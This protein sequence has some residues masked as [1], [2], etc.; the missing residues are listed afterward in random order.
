MSLGCILWTYLNQKKFVVSAAQPI[1]LYQLCMGCIVMATAIFPLSMQGKEST[2]QLDKACMSIPWLLFLGFVISVSAILAKTWRLE[3]LVGS[4]H[5]MRRVKVKARD[6]MKPFIALMVWNVAML[7]GWTIVSPLKY[8]R[9][10]TNNFDIFGRSLESYGR[11]ESSDSWVYLFAGLA[12]AANTCGV[13]FAAYKCYEVRNVTVYFSE[14]T[15]LTWSMAS[16]TETLL[17]GAP[18]LVVV[19]DDPSAFFLVAASL[20]CVCCWAFLL[21]MF[22]SKLFHK[23]SNYKDAK[24]DGQ[25]RQEERLYSVAVGADSQFEDEYDGSGRINIRR[26]DSTVSS[27]YKSSNCNN[28]GGS[29]HHSARN[30]P[31]TEMSLTSHEGFQ[32]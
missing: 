4:A 8:V 9:T 24:I 1:F 20:I 18:I 5:G 22:V 29:S 26:F 30:C 12:C 23:N 7:I 15:Y 2:P 11:C 6:V 17:L 10:P 28:W 32:R 19:K 31:R 3:K 25:R 21:P 27:Q 13:L 14:T 16:L